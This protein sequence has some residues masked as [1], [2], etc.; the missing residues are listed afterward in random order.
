MRCVGCGNKIVRGF[1]WRQCRVCGLSVSEN[2]NEE[3]V[4]KS[5]HSNGYVVFESQGTSLSYSWNH[6]KGWRTA[7]F[8]TMLVMGEL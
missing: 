7:P 8:G 2:S 4:K 1:G 3:R 6:D 5:S